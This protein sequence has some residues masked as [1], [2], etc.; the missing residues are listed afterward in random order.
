VLV[1]TVA[2]V[3][4]AVIVLPVAVLAMAGGV[5]MRVA[6]AFEGASRSALQHIHNCHRGAAATR[7]QQATGRAARGQWAQP[8]SA[9]YC[10]GVSRYSLTESGLLSTRSNTH[11]PRT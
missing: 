6:H 9:T 10:C 7:S 3:V 1:V 11:R 4:V 5:R 8:S 2:A